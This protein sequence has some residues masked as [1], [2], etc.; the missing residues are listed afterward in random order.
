M[1]PDH[2]LVSRLENNRQDLL[3]LRSRWCN[4]FASRARFDFHIEEATR[5]ADRIYG[6]QECIQLTWLPITVA[7][8]HDE[9]DDAGDESSPEL[10][11]LD[12]EQVL[13]AD[14]SINEYEKAEKECEET[15]ESFH[16]AGHRA[17]IHWIDLVRS[18][19]VYCPSPCLTHPGYHSNILA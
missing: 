12:T 17:D 15:E 14:I 11:D 16:G 10:S 4:E 13:S 5:V 18:M 1:L 6:Q 8:E 3:I 7:V 2:L 9:P 19:L